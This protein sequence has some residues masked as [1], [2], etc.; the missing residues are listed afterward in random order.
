MEDQ[1]YGLR[2]HDDSQAR[3]LK[4]GAIVWVNEAVAVEPGDPVLLVCV[5]TT[6]RCRYVRVLRDTTDDGFVVVEVCSEAEETFSHA[7]WRCLAVT[8]ITGLHQPAESAEQ[9]AA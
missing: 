9:A 8:D 2:V 4:P 3:W 7:D 6:D 1:Q 5:D